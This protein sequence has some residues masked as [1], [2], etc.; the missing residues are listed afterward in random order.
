MSPPPEQTP[1]D[2]SDMQTRPGRR[3]YW[4]W[5]IAGLSLGIG[6]GVAYGWYFLYNRTIPLIEAQLTSIL[7]RPVDL[8][9]IES[10]SLS[11]LRLGPSELPPTESDPDRIEIDR[12]AIDYNLGEILWRRVVNARVTVENPRV[13]IE[14]APDGAWVDISP[15]LPEPAEEAQELPVFFASIDATVRDA[16]VVLVPRQPSGELAAEYRATFPNLSAT[17]TNDFGQIA[18]AVGGDLEV[19]T[20]AAAGDVDFSSGTLEVTQAR[21]QGVELAQFLPFAA[22]YVPVAVEE[23]AG[24]VAT[25]LTLSASL[26]DPLESWSGTGTIALTDAIA[27]LASLRQPATAAADLRLQGSTIVV[28][29]LDGQVG[30]ALQAVVSGRLDAETGYDLVATIPSAQLA[31]ILDAVE[32]ESP[33][34][35]AVGGAIAAEARITGALDGPQISAEL[36]TPEPL[37]VDGET[38]GTL[39]VAARLQDNRAILDRLNLAAAAG[40]EILADG[41]YDLEAQAWSA[42]FDIRDLS[43]EVARPYLAGSLLNDLGRLNASGSS[44]GTLADLTGSVATGDFVWEGEIGR[45]AA[46]R[47]RLAERE[48]TADLGLNNVALQDFIPA[49]APGA[50]P[51]S[52]QL[53]LAATLPAD[54]S[55]EAKPLEALQ[56]RASG[57]LQAAGI[58][59]LVASR[60]QLAEREL[61]ANFSLDN[62][63]LQDFTPFLAPDAAPLSGQ[64]QIAA[65]LPA[66]LRP[67]AEPLQEL[68]ARASGILRAAGGS[69]RLQDVRLQDGRWQV[70]AN[71]NDFPLG[72]IV[73]EDLPPDLLR[74]ARLRGSARASGSLERPDD[75]A[76]V[77]LAATAR[78]DGLADGTVIIPNLRLQAS[79]LRLQAQ[80]AG[81][82]LDRLAAAFGVP[83][84][85]TPTPVNSQLEAALPLNALLD[86]PGLPTLREL[87]ASA[88]FEFDRGLSVITEPLSAAITWDGSRLNLLQASS[89]QVEARGFVTPNLEATGLDVVGP[90]NLD[91]AAEDLDLA[92]VPLPPDIAA[93]SGRAGF[94]GTIRGEGLRAL[95]PTGTPALEEIAIAPQV[96]GTLA[97]RNL[98]VNDY[99]FDP[100]LSG[101]VRA[102]L[103]NGLRVALVGEND[104][105]EVAAS[106]ADP[107]RPLPV[108][109]QALRLRLREA[110]VVG[111]RAGEEFR[112]TL[113]QIPL[114]QFQPLLPPNLAIGPAGGLLEGELSANLSDFGVRGTVSLAR[115]QIP[116]LPGRVFR[117][118][119]L[120]ADFDLSPQQGRATLTNGRLQ[121]GGSDYQLSAEAR[122]NPDNL[123]DLDALTYEA[124]LSVPQARLQDALAALQIRTLAD[125]NRN[126]ETPIYGDASDLDIEPPVEP[127]ASLGDRLER[128]AEI[129]QQIEA[130]RALQAQAPLPPLSAIVGDFSINASV[131][132][133]GLSPQTA[134]GEVSLD[135]QAWQWG[136]LAAQQVE[137]RLE[138]EDGR[139]TVL[140]V[141]LAS[142][143]SSIELTGSTTLD[144]GDPSLNFNLVVR[145]V[146][147]EL[148]RNFVQFPPAI[149]FGGNFEANLLVAG[150]PQ[151]PSATG[152][153]EVAKATINE[154][155][156]ERVGGSFT[157]R[158]S[159]LLFG[160]DGSIATDSDPVLASGTIPLQ[161]PTSTIAPENDL[162]DV[163]V[164][165]ENDALAFL[166]VLTN[167]QLRWGGGSANVDLE[168][169]GPF[170]LANPR[171]EALTGRGVATFEEARLVSAILAEPIEAING[172]AD[173]DL[174]RLTTDGI[175]ARLGGGDLTIAGALPFFVPSEDELVVT[176]GTHELNALDGLFR[177][178]VEGTIRA[179]GTALATRIGGDVRASSGTLDLA[180]LPAAE[181]PPQPPAE[182][183]ND[184]VV[185][186]AP[187]T[188]R[189]ALAASLNLDSELPTNTCQFAEDTP[190]LLQDFGIE[191]GPL[192]SVQV[193]VVA[194][195]FVE[196]QFDLNGP[197]LEVPKLCP[198]GTVDLTRGTVA[199][200]STRFRLD[201]SE[202]QTATFVPEQGLDPTLD[203]SLQ[204][205][206]VETTRQPEIADPSQTEIAESSGISANALGSSQTVDVRARVQGRA[207]SLIAQRNLGEVLSLD[208]TPSRSESEILA[209]IGQGALGGGSALGLASSLTGGIQAAIAD[210]LGLSEFSVFPL[211]LADDDD[212]DDDSDDDG[213]GTTSV[214]LV[215]ETGIDITDSIT[216]SILAV[217]T[218]QQPPIYSLRYRITERIFFRAFTDFGVNEQA[219]INYETRF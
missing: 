117:G 182:P 193:P 191:V 113:N 110:E 60:L 194:S 70:D 93:V 124:N 68:Q 172:R 127:N 47:F 206:V 9:D 188:P 49:V 75:L 59:Q 44:S 94:V 120:S 21:L 135:G 7:G 34:P 168:V 196:G 22:S 65:T 165:L 6:G 183:L 50:A 186:V 83:G 197:L 122:L 213:E 39:E 211:P 102:D 205:Q 208:S 192:F 78:L 190:L 32:L 25:D 104:V 166:D 154:T 5:A 189:D 30:E 151:E 86:S 28:E 101:P 170:E 92:R 43:G 148:A 55:P 76:A 57:I 174:N 139:L 164:S 178:K 202:P 159:Q 108:E 216:L 141:R 209:L 138:L 129:S 140:P 115:P 215:A 147:V 3:R 45:L 156:I 219:T 17:V 143:E 137:A 111:T 74:D 214:Q 153:F 167:Q 97:L 96:D 95:P 56:V 36:F 126:F 169:T 64:L 80:T 160:F 199:I 79:N 82:R 116:L 200:G 14:Q 201:K 187:P 42:K 66:D 99:T 84:L 107:G 73:L 217:L 31:A 77:A 103:E 118:E 26:S 98:K 40:G 1:D 145:D 212:D 184:P 130:Q 51:L 128:F 114:E 142:G 157:Y 19:G 179:G 185:A 123:Q 63:D 155:P 105:I 218:D 12:I 133:E 136:N 203:V 33:P 210:A 109:P 41:S 2:S 27:R 132:G 144:L 13:Y 161:L 207:T 175:T 24:T 134:R 37:V 180:N 204:A 58:G 8:G 53:Q 88:Q 11:A 89:A 173:F 35:V 112:V 177:S 72:A 52:G 90:F 181:E 85:E 15:N 71:L 125:L 176:L 198:E 150:S 23:L 162:L 146:P 61:Q 10:L 29:R 121:F 171:L 91:V 4:L 152:E 54:L 163:R 195:F 106:L 119:S 38:L 87:S 67:E 20:I 81:V 16:E 158:R 131:A 48:L 62:V 100:R 18:F 69:A 46:S 149:G